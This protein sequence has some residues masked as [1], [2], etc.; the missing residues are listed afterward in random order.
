MSTCPRTWRAPRR[1]WPPRRW[2]RDARISVVVPAL[3]DGRLV[4]AAVR[5]RV[6][7]R[8][9]RGDSGRRRMAG[10]HHR[11]GRTPQAPGVDSA[12]RGRA[13]QMNAGAAGATGEVLCFLHADTV[14][15]HGWAEAVRD[16]LSATGAVATAFDSPYRSDARHS[17][18]VQASGKMRWRLTGTPYGDPGRYCVPRHVFR[19][20]W[21]LSGHPGDGGP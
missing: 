10:R 15:P 1:C 5:K 12:Q 20:A 17:A 2:A 7:R 21:R 8:G 19:G 9:E 3:D 11:S 14:L 4:G 18:I 16:M 13:R 6:R